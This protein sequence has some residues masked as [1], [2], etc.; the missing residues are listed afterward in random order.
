MCEHQPHVLIIGA[1]SMGIITGYHLS[2]AGAS[3]AFLVRPHRADALSRPQILY[4]YND[5]TLKEYMGY[6]FFTDPSEMASASYDYIV[7]TLDAASLRNDV[8][9]RLV[10]TIGDAARGTNTKVILGS[11]F[12]DLRRWFLLVSGLADE[13]VTNG[14]LAIHA[15]SP[16]AVT[17]PLHVPTDSVL[18]AKSDLAYADRLPQGFSLDDSAPEVANAFMALYNGCGVS[19]CTVTSAVEFSVAVNPIFAV[20]AACALMDWPAFQGISKNGELWSLAVKAVREIQGLGMHGEP[21]KL[22]MSMTT[23]EGVAKQLA[24][25]ERDMR[26][27]DFQ[28]FNQFHHGGKVNKQDRELL[29]AC[30]EY[31]EAEGM[32]MEALKK[33]VALSG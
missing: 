14:Y 15:Y 5:N 6:T 19:R 8:G 22:A 27:L 2:L 10:K 11:V 25:V 32:K 26:P 31:G 23:E 21:G 29:E 13:Q 4:S 12:L 3:V 24:D 18:L 28:A 17:L 16:Q 7:I 33:L 30:V 1:G 20:F 9:Q